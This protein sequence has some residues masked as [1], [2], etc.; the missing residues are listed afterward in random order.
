MIFAQGKLMIF[1]D[2]ICYSKFCVQLEQANC[3]GRY[4]AVN[5]KKAPRFGALFLAV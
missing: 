1:T 2:N 5:Y 4:S 3:H